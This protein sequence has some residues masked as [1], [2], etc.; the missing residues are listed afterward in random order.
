MNHSAISRQKPNKRFK[1]TDYPFSLVLKMKKSTMP[2]EYTCDIDIEYTHNHSLT[3]LQS[4][5][6]QD[7]PTEVS[8]RITNLFEK[9]LTP[10]LA[11]RE[12]L[13]QVKAVSKDDLELHLNLAN[14]SIMPRRRDFNNLYT[15]FHREKFGTKDINSMFNCLEGK[16]IFYFL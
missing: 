9:G 15:E 1:N 3:S 2:S 4:L 12:M 16:N 6:F 7:I 14:R 11:Y 10:G 8:D 5:S 13:Q